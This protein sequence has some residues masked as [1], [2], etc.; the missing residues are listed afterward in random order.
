MGQILSRPKVWVVADET[1]YGIVVID[2]KNGNEVVIQAAR[3]DIQQFNATSR[4]GRV[5]KRLKV[6]GRHTGSDGEFMLVKFAGVKDTV[7]VRRPTAEAEAVP[8]AESA[9]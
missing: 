5:V 9:A 6:L 8:A 1:D 2:A 7:H 3:D 4:F